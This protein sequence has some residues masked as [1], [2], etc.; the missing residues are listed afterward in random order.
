MLFHGVTIIFS[1]I[2]DLQKRDQ[3]DVIKGMMREVKIDWDRFISVVLYSSSM[4]S[5]AFS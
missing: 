3:F 5:E 1:A 2:S 4:F